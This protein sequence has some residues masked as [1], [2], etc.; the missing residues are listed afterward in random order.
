MRVAV[1]GHAEPLGRLLTQALGADHV[2]DDADLTVW[3]PPAG[4]ADA[5]LTSALA[6][7]EVRG[8]LVVWSTDATE[9]TVRSAAEALLGQRERCWILQWRDVYGA[10]QDALVDRWL[11]AW[12]A[13]EAA[14]ADGLVHPLPVQEALQETVRWLHTLGTAPSGRHVVQG[15]PRLA[16]A[17]AGRL[18][19]VAPGD[20][21][22]WSDPAPS[23][24]SD[25]E[26]ALWQ[27]AAAC[28]L[29]APSAPR[30]PFVRANLALSPTL[31]ARWSTSVVSGQ[32]SNGGPQ[33]QALEQELARWRG[34]DDAVVVGSGGLALTLMAASLQRPGAV[35]VPTFTYPAT[36]ASFLLQ[37]REV[38]LADIRT[39]TLTVDPDAVARCCA[40]GGV[41]AIVAV[42][43]F[44]RAPDLD[45]LLPIAERHGCAL[46][47]DDAHGLAS[48]ARH[49]LPRA[50][51]LHATKHLAAAEGGA[52]TGPAALLARVRQLRDHG[53]AQDSWKPGFNARMDELRAALA[54][55]QLEQLPALV[56]RRHAHGLRIRE[57]LVRRGFEV[58][59]LAPGSRLLNLAA[60]RPGT[61][62][63]LWLEAFGSRGIE[64]RRYFAVPLHQLPDFPD[65]DCPVCD[66]VFEE[67]FC[68]PLHGDM[69]EEDLAAILRAI[70]EVR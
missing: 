15:P 40:D 6:A 62:A 38:R 64:A 36:A 22:P 52:I 37:G 25:V 68:L 66:Q 8:P 27:H 42:N 16:S 33:V 23:L 11:T 59:Q 39:D 29:P 17:L 21:S 69:R 13:G 46:W 35:V 20:G 44:G 5:Y 65:A 45:A 60:R 70:E 1:L 54:R 48:E 30:V 63:T 53:K 2:T 4:G 61:A 26:A 7:R 19:P 18:G 10:Q 50:F 57:A 32:L 47:V 55:Q 41:A 34:V 31:L 49:S 14:R 43:V 12:A 24:S 9:R 28:G 56:Q 58:Q 51:S 67:S 3:V